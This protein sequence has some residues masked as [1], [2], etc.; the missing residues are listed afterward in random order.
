MKKVLVT[1]ALAVSAQAYAAEELHLYNWNNYLSESTAKSFEAYC[2][3]KLV[4]DFYGDNEEM[5]AKLAAGA[6]GYDIV[7]PTGFAVEALIKQGKAQPLDK[8]QLPNFK[9]LNAG[10]LNSFFDK[11][12][13]YSVPYAF[14]TTLLGYNETKLK[15]LGL[16]DK[17]NSWALIFDPAVLAKLKGKI[18]VLDSQRELVSAALMYL[19]KPA[20][21]TNPADW[22]AARD[23]ILKAKPYWAA[24]N[25]Q[26]YIKELTVGNIY[27][28]LGY[29]NDMYQAQQDAKK[30]GRKF[31][32]NFGLQ[33]EG[34][35]LSLDNFV[36]LKDAPRKDL[37]YKFI[38]FMLDG[39]NASGLTNEMGSGN[40]NAAA[41]K[42]VKPELTKVHAIFPTASELPRLQQLKDLN[43]KDRRELNKVWSEIKLK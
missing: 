23:V 40:P 17:A 26:S 15:E 36:I 10:Y 19:G 42:F 30:A 5:L 38:N 43:A 4:Q 41:G 35:T 13:Q 31:G 21:S 20:N 12:N 29:S 34:N 2:K 32:V 22:K 14:T 6:K 9:N 11:G 18:T 16:L 39:K 28:A 3:C 27:V 33:K 24:F 7:V 1:L 8:K 37:A 25:N